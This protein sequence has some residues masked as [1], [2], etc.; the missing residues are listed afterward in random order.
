MPLFYYAVTRAGDWYFKPLNWAW[1]RTVGAY[2]FTLYLCHF[3]VILALEAH[4]VALGSWLMI[5][6][7]GGISLIYAALVHW[8]VEQPVMGLRHRFAR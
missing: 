3:C 1:V 5:V 6:A 4:G 2:S 7:A 8:W